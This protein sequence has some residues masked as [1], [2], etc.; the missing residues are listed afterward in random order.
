MEDGFILRS[1]SQDARQLQRKEWLGVMQRYF[2]PPEQL[3]ESEAIVTGD[4]AHHIANVM[5]AR[6]GDTIII[7]NGDNREVLAKLEHIS[8]DRVIADVVE[9]LPMLA[10]PAIRVTIA[11]S[12]PKGDKLETVIQKGTEIG[13][14]RFLPFVSERTVVQY[15]A[16]KESKRLERWHKIAKEAAEQAHRNRIPAVEPPCSWKQLMQAAREADKAFFCYEKEE[17]TM[18]KQAVVQAI[19]E[20][21]GTAGMNVMLIVGPEGGFTER[22]AA[23]AEAAGCVCVKLGRRILRTETAG[24]VGLT[25]LLY[26]AG[27]MGG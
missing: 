4:D 24:M 9:P 18:L 12:L 15:D 25:C 11:Q 14:V 26:E 22:E 1:D 20:R 19:A 6:T 13:A 21:G 2:I 5:R 7:S 17:G 8:K 10:E 23:E 3:T 27:E 16:K